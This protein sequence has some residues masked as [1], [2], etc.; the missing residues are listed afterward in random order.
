MIVC[1]QPEL[2]YTEGAAS[3][4]AC[5]YDAS[6]IEYNPGLN[7]MLL[8]VEDVEGFISEAS[9]VS[10]VRYAEPN[11]I[12]RALYTPDDPYYEYQWALPAINASTAWDYEKGNASVKIAIVD[13]GVQYLSLIHI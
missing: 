7:C 13:T 8:S 12:V 10:G 2:N 6:V 11:Y 3:V 5:G 9:G 1:L 4:T